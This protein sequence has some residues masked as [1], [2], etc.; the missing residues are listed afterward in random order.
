MRDEH[1]GRLRALAEEYVMLVEA[2]RGGRYADSDEWQRMSSD[3]MLVHDELL[4]LTG[5]TRCD[6][7]YRYCRELLAGTVSANPAPSDKEGM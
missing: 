5:M 2:M 1:A 4:L 7:M 3:R 6:D